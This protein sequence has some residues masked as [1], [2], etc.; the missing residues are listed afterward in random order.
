VPSGLLRKARLAPASPETLASLTALATHW[1]DHPAAA[2]VLEL[3]Q[4]S[5]SPSVRAAVQREHAAT[6][7]AQAR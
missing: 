7:H 5:T 2:P 4:H 3:A 1:A 6:P